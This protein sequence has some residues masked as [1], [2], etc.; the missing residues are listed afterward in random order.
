MDRKS[1]T[2][3]YLAA[4]SVMHYDGFTRGFTYNPNKYSI[5]TKDAK[6][7]NTIGQRVGPSFIDFK[8]IN[9]AYCGQICQQKLGCQHSGYEDPNN[10]MQCKCPG[11]FGG[12]L[13]E[14]AAPSSSGCGGV[15]KAT[16]EPQYITSP[17][18]PGQYSKGLQCNWYILAPPSGRIYLTF[19]GTF[20]LPCDEIC[21]N[22]YVEVKPFQDFQRT[23][24]RFC[25][26][27]APDQIVAESNE[28]VVIFVS[29][30]QVGNG[31]RAAVSTDST[32][33]IVAPTAPPPIQIT[34]VPVT[35]Q[36]GQ[37]PKS[38]QVQSMI[39]KK[40][41]QFIEQSIR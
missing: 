23:G 8:L 12:R 21:T 29:N 35:V 32:G 25:C 33:A 13:C 16:K 14:S 39:M 41:D 38:P 1:G 17:G 28:M 9:M 10:C 18:Y 36:A 20:S 27:K 4:K 30:G 34:Q 24:Y 7:Q 5:S 31:F 6:F 22:S 15:I 2:A 19:G 37:T 11:G 40:L 26:T 3:R